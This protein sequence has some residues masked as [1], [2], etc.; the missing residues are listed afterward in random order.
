MEPARSLRSDPTHP[1]DA[2]GLTVEVLQR[3]AA[4]P[5][6]PLA[7]FEGRN[8]LLRQSAGQA[9]QESDGGLRDYRREDALHVREDGRMLHQLFRQV[10]DTGSPGLHPFEL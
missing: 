9:E 1:D 2:D 5:S 3:N 7:L 10:L 8:R 6:D 4:L